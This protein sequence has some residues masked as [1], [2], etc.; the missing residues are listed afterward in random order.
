MGDEFRYRCLVETRRLLLLMGVVFGMILFIQYFEHPYSDLLSSFLAP[1]ESPPAE[2]H[3][4]PSIDSSTGLGITDTADKNDLDEVSRSIR[5]SDGNGSDIP[6]VKDDFDHGNNK[7]FDST[8]NNYIDPEGE[9]PTD[10]F[11]AID[12]N[13]TSERVDSNSSFQSEMTSENAVELPSPRAYVNSATSVTSEGQHDEPVL[14]NNN[15][16]IISK[17]DSALPV[18]DPSI[19]NISITEE[20]FEGPSTAVVT[21]SEMN[22]MLLQSRVSYKAMVCV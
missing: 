13:S 16:P 15:K 8:A 10:D 18:S 3:I 4:F 17:P 7:S 2:V 1:S 11:L 12:H 19:S 14:Q 9:S 21:I 6:S 5:V 20:G 22:D